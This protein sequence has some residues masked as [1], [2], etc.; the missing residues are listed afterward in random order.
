MSLLWSAKSATFG[1]GPSSCLVEPQAAA[2]STTARAASENARPLRIRSMLAARVR[3]EPEVAAD[4]AVP[5]VAVVRAGPDVEG[6]PLPIGTQ[7]AG[8]DAVGLAERVLRT[9]VYPD[10]SAGQ[11]AARREGDHVVACEVGCV[12]E[13]AGRR[14]GAAEPHRGR[15]ASDRAEA[16]AS[17]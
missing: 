3:V 8:E 10:R 1:C 11:R 9:D 7:L 12:V 14:V 15:V 16:A 4:V 2:Q 13:G 6:D 17:D 5:V